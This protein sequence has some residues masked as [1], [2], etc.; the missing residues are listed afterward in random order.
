[1][2]ICIGAD[3]RGFSLKEEIITYLKSVGYHVVD[4]G[5]SEYDEND[6]Y[7]EFAAKT[8]EAV[9]KDPFNHRG[10]V[11]CG[12]GV[13]V[14][15]VA[16]KFRFIRSVLSFSPEHAAVSREHD[17]TNV[18]ALGADMLSRDEAIQIVSA[19]L[20]TPFDNDPQHLKRIQDIKDIETR[21]GFGSV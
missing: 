15:I 1:M 5:N 16:N 6:D 4:C 13:G 2:V 9:S 12:S 17:D 7:P 3:H 14:D 20:D 10:I 11:I 8:A 19:W 18:L 21:N